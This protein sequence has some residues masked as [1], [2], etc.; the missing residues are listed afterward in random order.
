MKKLYLFGHVWIFPPLTFLIR[1]F[2]KLIFSWKCG[3]KNCRV[4]PQSFLIPE[5]TLT[6]ALALKWQKDVNKNRNEIK[7]LINH[8]FLKLSEEKKYVHKCFI[9]KFAIKWHKK[10]N[11]TFSYEA[12]WLKQ[13]HEQMF[14]KHSYQKMFHHIVCIT[15]HKKLF[16][17]EALWLKKL[18]KQMTLAIKMTKRCNW[19]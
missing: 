18:H 15:W 11:S 3:F 17:S 5:I 8:F 2:S 19:K 14:K 10:S 13:L 7:K 4:S 1:F 16:L 6:M 9:T 12:F